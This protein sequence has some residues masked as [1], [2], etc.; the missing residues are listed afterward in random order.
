MPSTVVAA[1]RLT[2]ASMVLVPVSL[3]VCRDS[4]LRI[5]RRDVWL[6]VLSGAFLAVHFATWISSLEH[7]S[8]ASSVALVSTAPIFV[9]LASP[10]VLGEFVPRRT[11][12]GIFLAVSGAAVI[13]AFHGADD[14]AREGVLGPTLALIGAAGV[15]GYFLIGRRVRARMGLLPY[16]TVSYGAA[17]VLLIAWALISSHSLFEWSQEAY[18]ACIGLAIFPQLLG[19]STYNWAL[20][21]LSA[22][23]VSVMVIGEPIGS[24]IL[25]FF[26]FQEMPSGAE[27]LGC[28][29]LLVGIL[30]VCWKTDSERPPD[31]VRSVEL[32]S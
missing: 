16:I 14:A 27:L 6:C 28:A 25:A 17:A 32:P 15:A 2:F 21:H 9:A 19:H 24:A 31:D 7:C 10:W 4:L 1:L 11:W 30:V 13:Y 3:V 26:L 20:K 8:V 5:S 12:V 18:L 29:F 22:S 23:A